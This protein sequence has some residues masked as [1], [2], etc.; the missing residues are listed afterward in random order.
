M[1]KDCRYGRP[2]PILVLQPLRSRKNMPW[3]Y[4][5]F[6]IAIAGWVSAVTGIYRI[7]EATGSLYRGMSDQMQPPALR[8][9][10]QQE[11]RRQ[12]YE[13]LRSPKHRFERMLIITGAGLFFGVGITAIA[14]ASLAP[15]CVVQDQV[16]CIKRS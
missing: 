3:G 2:D 11:T 5:I 4:L 12:F 7:M 16:W 10:Q 13:A 8:L 1:I 14:A 6:G 9:A 15:T